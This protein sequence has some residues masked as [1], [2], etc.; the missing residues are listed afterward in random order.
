M[1]FIKSGLKRFD[2]GVNYQFSQDVAND[3]LPAIEQTNL[4]H[5]KYFDY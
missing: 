5:V 4:R 3:P 1:K 2:V